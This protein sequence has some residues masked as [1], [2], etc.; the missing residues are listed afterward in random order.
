MPERLELELRAL[1]VEWPETPDIAGAVLARLEAAPADAGARHPRRALAWRP[2]LAYGLAAVVAALAVTMAVSPAARSAILEFL[3]LKG[4]KIER[5]EPTATP[6]PEPPAPL[7]AD[8]GLGRRRTLA[9]ARREAGF[10]LLVP[11]VPRLGAPD[12]VYLDDPLGAGVRVSLVYGRRRGIP[13]SE[14]TG[15][16]LLVMLLEADV[17]R[18]VIGKATGGGA[19]VDP[20]EVDGERGYFIS[21]QPHGFAFVNPYGEASFE[22]QRLAGRTLLLEHGDLLLRVEGEVSRAEAIAIARSMR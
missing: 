22:E 2:A 8:L 19:V 1:A 21:G 15:A 17:N 6:R 20:L 4:A 16:A 18:E 13:P 11:A 5:R 3:G 7:G 14:H 12:A 10:P 9:Q